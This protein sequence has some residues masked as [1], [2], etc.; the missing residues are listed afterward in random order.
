MRQ[1]PKKTG[2]P[3]TNNRRERRPPRPSSRCACARAGPASAAGGA[4]PVAVGEAW[5]WLAAITRSR[6]PSVSPLMCVVLGHRSVVRPSASFP[7]AARQWRDALACGKP[8]SSH[9]VCVAL[10]AGSRPG[11]T[12]RSRNSRP[13][14][15]GFRMSSTGGF[16]GLAGAGRRVAAPPTHT[17]HHQDACRDR[18]TPSAHRCVRK[19]AIAHTV[20]HS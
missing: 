7:V 13:P 15:T 3:N 19:T 2:E 6:P 14:S 1:R 4:P 11:T 10:Y 12:N 17:H 18:H 16:M 8:D 9:W 5:L 20:T